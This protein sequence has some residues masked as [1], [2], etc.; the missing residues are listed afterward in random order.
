MSLKSSHTAIVARGSERRF[1]S[2]L[3][4]KRVQVQVIIDSGWEDLTALTLT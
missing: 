1:G 4:V 3:G 2:D